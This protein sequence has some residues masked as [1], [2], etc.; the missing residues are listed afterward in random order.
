MWVKMAAV[1]FKFLKTLSLLTVVRPPVLTVASE[2]GPLTG[3]SLRAFQLL[4]PKLST[5]HY[6]GAR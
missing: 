3:S 6:R 5:T 4:T 2:T 1:I